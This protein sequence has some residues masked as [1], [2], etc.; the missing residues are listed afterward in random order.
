M[1]TT[2]L[3]QNEYRIFVNHYS[4]IGKKWEKYRKQNLRRTQKKVEH[5]EEEVE[6]DPSIKFATDIMEEYQ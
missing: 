2:E 3:W 1:K 6:K 5:V 4:Q